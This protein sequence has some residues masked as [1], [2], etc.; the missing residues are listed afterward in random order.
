[1]RR[2]TRKLLSRAFLTRFQR[3]T[4]VGEFSAAIGSGS[5]Y[6]RCSSAGDGR[7]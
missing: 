1:M 4:A 3:G 7:R 2:A 6:T 5:I